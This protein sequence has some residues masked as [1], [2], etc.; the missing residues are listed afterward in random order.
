MGRLM[1]TRALIVLAAVC[2]V[3]ILAAFA[4]QILI[5]R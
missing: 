4:V 3:A 5:A 2:G 1:S